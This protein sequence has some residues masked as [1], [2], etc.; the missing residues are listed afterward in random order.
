MTVT[1]ACGCLAALPYPVPAPAVTVLFSDT[2]EDRHYVDREHHLRD[3]EKQVN[4]WLCAAVS[5]EATERILG[6]A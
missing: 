3:A 5:A 1:C 2:G 4:A 6:A